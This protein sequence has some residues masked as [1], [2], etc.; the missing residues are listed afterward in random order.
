MDNAGDSGGGPGD[1]RHRNRRQGAGKLQLPSLAAKRPERERRVR[2][3][4]TQ[5]PHG[6]PGHL[7]GAG[8]KHP[9]GHQRGYVTYL[10]RI[11]SGIKNACQVGYG[12]QT[13]DVLGAPRS[14]SICSARRPGPTVA[15][16]A[17]GRINRPDDATG[18][19]S[20][21]YPV[22]NTRDH[23]LTV[24]HHGSMPSAYPWRKRQGLDLR[25]VPNLA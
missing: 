25:F 14:V 24:C 18:I 23:S 1:G 2:V 21:P 9:G 12:N 3:V 15:I 8:A 7:P 6:N 5:Q 13:E 10:G 22:L 19:N 16:R 17:T 11:K 4:G 20:I